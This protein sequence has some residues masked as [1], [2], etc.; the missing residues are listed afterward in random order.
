MLQRQAVFW[1]PQVCDFSRRIRFSLGPDMVNTLMTNY[2]NVENHP[3]HTNT[4]GPILSQYP[5]GRSSVCVYDPK[6]F[7]QVKINPTLLFSLPALFLAVHFFASL[8]LFQSPLSII[9]TTL[10][11]LFACSFYPT[12]SSCSLFQYPVLQGRATSCHWLKL[13]PLKPLLFGHIHNPNSL[14]Y[15][16]I[17]FS[18]CS[19]FT[20]QLQSSRNVMRIQCSDFGSVYTNAK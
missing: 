7:W 6:C 5:E 11:F 17:N 15:K 20:V 2:I 14:G 4:N 18:V 9:Q 10:L 13:L 3:S 8:F 19:S 16:T 12:E 1:W